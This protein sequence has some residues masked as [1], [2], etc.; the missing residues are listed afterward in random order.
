MKIWYR[1]FLFDEDIVHLLWWR[2]G[3]VGAEDTSELGESLGGGRRR[4]R[5]RRLALVAENGNRFCLDLCYAW[6]LGFVEAS[7]QVSDVREEDVHVDAV[8]YAF[9]VSEELVYH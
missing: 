3:L 6:S 1:K 4:R 8:R 9:S 5:G 2:C 7:S